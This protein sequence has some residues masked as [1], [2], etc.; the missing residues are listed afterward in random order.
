[1]TFS[2]VARCPRTSEFGVGALTAVM[3][4]GKLVGHASP[5]VGAVASQASMNPYLA[6]D[7][8]RLMAEGAPPGQLSTRSSAGI[9]GGRCASAGSSIDSGPPPRGR[10]SARW[11]GPGTG[12]AT[13][14][15]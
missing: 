12:R 8:L 14:W 10:A 11:G 6:I 5:G 7:G 2:I 15:W 13:A 9:R 4:V 1:M 3:G